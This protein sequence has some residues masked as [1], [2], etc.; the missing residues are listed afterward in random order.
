MKA[1]RIAFEK[2]EFS[3]CFRE[4]VERVA[5]AQH[6]V[7]IIAQHSVFSH[8]LNHEPQRVPKSINVVEDGRFLVVAHTGLRHHVEHLVECAHSAWQRDAH[9]GAADD[10]ILSVAEVFAWNQLVEI[11]QG[12]LRIVEKH[13]RH[14]ADS[15]P[16]GLVHAVGHAAHQPHVATAEDDRVLFGSQIFTQFARAR[17]I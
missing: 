15:S 5:E 10:D 11:G 8:L 3:E 9:V 7:E 1:K 17:I 14:H 4:A 16:A 2:S 13:F 12:A 6:L